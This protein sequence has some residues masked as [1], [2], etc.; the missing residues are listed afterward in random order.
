MILLHGT[1]YFIYI[2]MILL[3]STLYFI[4]I[5]MILLHGTLY[6]ICIVMILLHGTLYNICLIMT[7]QYGTPSWVMMLQTCWVIPD[8]QL[9]W[10]QKFNVLYL[11][12]LV[13]R[14]ARHSSSVAD[15]AHRRFTSHGSPT[16]LSDDQKTIKCEWNNF[17]NF[18]MKLRK[19]IRLW[20]LPP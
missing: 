7:L 20:C 16:F 9:T 6:F 1:L 14:L 15:T 10:I 11:V 8:N 5:V 19:S 18:W 13:T 2:V 4:C 12:S 17:D 3:Q